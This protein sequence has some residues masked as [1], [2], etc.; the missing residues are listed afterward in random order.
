MCA[1]SSVEL[2]L[3]EEADDDVDVVLEEGRIFRRM[4]V[5]GARFVA[6]ASVAVLLLVKGETLALAL[7]GV[8]VS[9]ATVALHDEDEC[10][11]G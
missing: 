5:R 6:A 3:A 1:G 2:L 10:M 11:F 7:V 8:S 9:S 4:I